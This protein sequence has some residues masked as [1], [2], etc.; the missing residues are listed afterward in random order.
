MPDATE[1]APETPVVEA[2]GAEIPSLGFG[3]WEL[4]GRT[5]REM[6]EEA[7][8][9][10]YRHLDTA[11]AYD[12]EEEVGRAFEA[13]GLDRTEVFL[14][15]KIWPDEYRPDD[16]RAAV[17][18]SLEKLR[19]DHVD[20]LHLHWPKFERTTL[21]ATIEE[22][23]RALEDGLTRHVGV[24][25]FNM[26]LLDR[27]WEVTGVPLAVHQLEYHPYLEQEAVLGATRERGM[28][29]TAYSPLARGEVA[30]DEALAEIGARYGKSAAQVALRWLVQQPDVNA[31]PRTSDPAHLRDNR[32]VFD[33]ELTAEEMER[34]SS[35]ARPDGRVISPAGLAPEWD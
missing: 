20:L 7:L 12:N 22:L 32:D 19:T 23:N 25:N 9:A 31:I 34:V 13:S 33:F 3:T 4:T 1:T 28:A 24:C 21:G 16:F 8:A 17:R 6:T 29:L 5:A 18:D 27:A 14:T 26:E 15:T 11:R 35:L 30:G 2:H 10:G